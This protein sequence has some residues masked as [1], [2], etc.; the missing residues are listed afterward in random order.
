MKNMFQYFL[1]TE[2]SAIFVVQSQ[3][4]CDIYYIGF[5]KVLRKFW[6]FLNTIPISI[7]ILPKLLLQSQFQYQYPVSYFLNINLNVNTAKQGSAISISISIPWFSFPQY[8]FHLNFNSIA[9][10]QYFFQYFFR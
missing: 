8:Q 1:N 3:Y 6:L 5:D 10:I 9:I 4:Y 7:S 2:F